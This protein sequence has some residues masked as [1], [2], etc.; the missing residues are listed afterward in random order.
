M[1]LFEQQYFTEQYIILMRTEEGHE[2]D[3]TN[4]NFSLQNSCTP[5]VLNDIM[6]TTDL[7]NLYNRNI[8]KTSLCIYIGQ[9][10]K[11]RLMRNLSLSRVIIYL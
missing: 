7:V 1:E 6:F 10:E 9:D 11:C 8:F 4:L 3:Y 2:K 5:Q